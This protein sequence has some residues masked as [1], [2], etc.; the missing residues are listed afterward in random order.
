MASEDGK[1][2]K[3]LPQPSSGWKVRTSWPLG[4]RGTAFSFALVAVLFICR[5][6]L[7][8]PQVV[9]SE[10]VVWEE[11]ELPPKV[12]PFKILSTGNK[13][14]RI[15]LGTWLSKTGEV[16]EAV[17]VAIRCGYRHID[18]AWIYGNE[19]EVGAAIQEAIHA[20]IV[21]REDL[22]ITSKLWITFNR[23]QDVRK[24]L[25]ESLHR[26]GLT[27]IDLYLVHWP[28]S[29][30]L[31][32]SANPRGAQA[33]EARIEVPLQETWSE[34]EAQ[35]RQ[36]VIRAIGVSNFGPKRLK[37]LLSFAAIKPAVNQVQK[38]QIASLSFHCTT[39]CCLHVLPIWTLNPSSASCRT[40]YL[41]VEHRPHPLPKGLLLDSNDWCR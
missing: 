32:Y 9:E 41:S 12:E 4:T 24:G 29:Y 19:E 34:L 40:T 17:S 27:Y 21:T 8:P 15:G 38:K 14:P 13:I 39:S 37:L 3:V 2:D 20:G 18:S 7:R 33:E 11:Q 36:G 31:E 5:F 1:K 16:K 25:T 30:K 6:R 10:G 22:F 28:L 26:L 23:R 35:H